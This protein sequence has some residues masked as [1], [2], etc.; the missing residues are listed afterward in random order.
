MAS[1]YGQVNQK[2]GT[3]TQ[4]APGRNGPAVVFNYFL[5]NRQANPRTG[6]TTAP[7][8][9]LEHRKKSGSDTSLQSQCR[10]R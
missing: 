6:W 1:G 9:A 10:Y 5:D 7:V 8:Q 2:R 4:L 3:L